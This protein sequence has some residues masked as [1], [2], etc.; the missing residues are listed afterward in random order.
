VDW[1]ESRAKVKKKQFKKSNFFIP[2]NKN[3]MSSFGD[4]GRFFKTA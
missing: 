4:L 1:I 2:K 3:G